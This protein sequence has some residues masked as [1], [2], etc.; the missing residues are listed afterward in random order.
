MTE[1][2]TA[3][4]TGVEEEAAPETPEAESEQ[5]PEAEPDGE[6]P[7]GEAEGDD[8]EQEPELREFDFGGNKLSVPKDAIPEEVAKKLDEFTKGTWS[9]YTKRSQ[10][11]AEK[12]K[13]LEARESAVQ[14]FQTLTDQT[15]KD[16]SRGLSLRAELEQLS[17]INQQELWQSNPDQARQLSDTLSRKQA[18]LNQ[19]IS[20]VARQE[21]EL[22]QTQQSEIA[23]RRQEG[24]VLVERQIKGFAEKAPEVVDYVVKNF[25]VKKESAEDWQLNPVAAVM[26][27]ESMM[28]RKM[29]AEAGKPAKP[30]PAPAVPLKPIKGKGGKATLDLVKDA[31]KLSPEEWVRRRNLQ[32]RNKEKAEA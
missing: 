19:V 28:Y 18:E 11:V 13:A 21:H 7:E 6:Q 9:D 17:Q 16:Y 30:Q 12:E 22:S 20:Q 10:T 3:P 14:K 25:G 24:A 29:K 26:A 15:L 1:E 2:S 5:E 32:Q 8:E 31:D 23:R 27:Y 4:D